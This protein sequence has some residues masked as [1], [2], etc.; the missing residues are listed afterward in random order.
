MGRQRNSSGMLRAVTIPPRDEKRQAIED[1]DT[2]PLQRVRRSDP[3]ASVSPATR[4][5]RQQD[6]QGDGQGRAKPIGDPPR[7]SGSVSVERIAAGRR[8]VDVLR[9]CVTH[10][11][12]RARVCP[13]AG[14]PLRTGTRLCRPITG[15]A[16]NG[17]VGSGRVG[18]GD[19]ARPT[20]DLGRPAVRP[21]SRRRPGPALKCWPSRS[22]AGA[23]YKTPGPVRGRRRRRPAGR[24]GHPRRVRGSVGRA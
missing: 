11:G 14:R 13:L 22:G 19:G 17:R 9:N 4:R 12:R 8:A 24:I 15:R 23:P 20:R 18:S 3:G 2:S 6:H 10:P 21:G 7:P 5:N 16:W 1:S